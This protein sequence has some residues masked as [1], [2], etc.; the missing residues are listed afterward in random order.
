MSD[1]SPEQ[2]AILTLLTRVEGLEREVARLQSLLSCMA[3]VDDLTTELLHLTHLP[4]RVDHLEW[5]A[6]RARLGRSAQ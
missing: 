6:H 4:K 1:L 5:A 3:T 2:A